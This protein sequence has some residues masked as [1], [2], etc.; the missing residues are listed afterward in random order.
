[1]KKLLML[2]ATA[3]LSVS[4]GTCAADQEEKPKAAPPSTPGEMPAMS[5]I[6]V[7]KAQGERMAEL[8]EKLSKES[9][10]EIRRRLMAEATCPQ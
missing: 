4:F 8:V 6:P 3:C 10:P 1:M 7:M 9:N 2:V 5:E